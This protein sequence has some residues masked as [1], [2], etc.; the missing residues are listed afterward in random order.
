VDLVNS[1]W[2]DH[3]GSSRTYDRLPLT[4][5]RR[6]FLARYGR[7]P[8]ETAD[9]PETVAGLRALRDV[10]R[11]LLEAFAERQ[12]I[13]A[14][15]VDALNDVLDAS[16]RVRRLEAAGCGYRLV[17]APATYDWRRALAEVAASAAEMLA[18]GEPARLRVCANP[19]CSWM[20]YDET[21]NGSR[22]WCEGAV[23]GN[24][25]KVRRHRARG[26]RDRL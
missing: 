22:R 18:A 26:G 3:L 14:A 9:A 24:L 21:R 4:E 5:W 2:T 13:A 6:A 7:L 1:R 12:P 10:I 11:P 19:A 15:N 23:C 20:F 17:D 25:L 16:P 8:S